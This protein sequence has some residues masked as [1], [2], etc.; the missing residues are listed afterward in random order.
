[1]RARSGEPYTT[2]QNVIGNAIQGGLN[3]TR[4]NWH[5]GI[6]LRLDKRFALNGFAKKNEAGEAVAANVKTKYYL[7]AFV[8]FQNI[9]NIKDVLG[10]YP[11]TSRPDDDGYVTSAT[12]KQYF[13]T[14]YNAQTMSALY[15]MYVNNPGFYNGPRRANIGVAFS[16]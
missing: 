11:Y 8:Y 10:V 15:A 6:D 3:G 16:F 5:F 13:N 9:F 2:Y 1:M 7:A 4:L 14:Q 12:G